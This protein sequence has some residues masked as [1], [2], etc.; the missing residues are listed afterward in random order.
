MKINIFIIAIFFVCCCALQAFSQEQTIWR[1]NNVI[2]DM[3]IDNKPTKIEAVVIKIK[4]DIITVSIET[5]DMGY[6][7]LSSRFTEIEGQN[8]VRSYPKELKLIT[9]KEGY[10][11]K[12]AKIALSENQAPLA[13]IADN[14]TYSNSRFIV[15]TF[16]ADF[17]IAENK[18]DGTMI[19]APP[20]RT[21]G[22]PEILPQIEANKK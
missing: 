22:I 6:Q 12:T 13:I 14:T 17:T 20:N 10:S 16:T 15:N 7:F 9:Q 8:S 3:N 4:E 19:S 21:I 2:G 18:R 5:K 1:T 11:I